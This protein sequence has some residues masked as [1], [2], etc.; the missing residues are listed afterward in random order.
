MSLFTAHLASDADP[1]ATACG[2]PWQGWQEPDLPCVDEVAGSPL[3]PH[4]EPGRNDRVRQ[5]QACF[6]VAVNTA[7][8][9]SGTPDG[10][11]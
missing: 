4:G 11:A 1:R 5:C 10:D 8:A 7:P 3:P 6:R 9:V 2:E